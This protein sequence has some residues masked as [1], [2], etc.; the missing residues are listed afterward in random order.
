MSKIVRNKDY[1]HPEHFADKIEEYNSEQRYIPVPLLDLLL[2]QA[3]HRCTVCNENCYELHHID[4]LE[5]GGKTEYNNLIA[6]CPNCHTRVHRENVPNPQQLRHYKLKLEVSYSL[7]I[8][9]KLTTEEKELILEISQY[10]SIEELLTYSQRFYTVIPNPDQEEAKKIY[11]KEIGF[12]NLELNEIIII[13]FGFCVTSAEQ[14]SSGINL[15][16]RL[17]PKGIKWINYLNETKRI[18]LL[19]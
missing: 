6:L 14:D 2:E 1:D 13:D 15:H 9:G 7:P 19:K 11:R 18:E 17:T 4:F 10:K 5:N 3:G 8:I 16:L 12:F